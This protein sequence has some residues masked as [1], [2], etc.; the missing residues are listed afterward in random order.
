MKDKLNKKNNDI[1]IETDV[2]EN[3]NVSEQTAEEKEFFER[4][5]FA[6]DSLK[7]NEDVEDDEMSS[8]E[9][10]KAF[11]KVSEPKNVKK[12]SGMK[13]QIIILVSVFL[14]AAILLGVYEFILK[15]GD[16]TDDVLPNIYTLSSNCYTIINQVENDVQIV[17]KDSEDALS[18]D[19]Y[20]KY[21][22]Y[23]AVTF[24]YEFDCVSLVYGEGDA[25][26]TVRSG[27][28]AV[29]YSEDEFFNTLE[30]GKRFSFNGERLYGAAI[31]EVTGRTDLGNAD[32]FAR[33]ALPGY[34]LDG[35]TL[36]STNRPFMYPSI[37]RSDVSNVV[38]TN[39]YGSYK[40]YRMESN[41]SYSS[42]FYFEGAEFC[43]YNQELFA[44]F[45]VNCTYVLTYGKVSNVRNLADFGLASD[46]DAN[47]II[48]I[49]TID[50]KYHK[51]LIGDEIPATGGY[52]AKYYNKDFVYILDSSY[53]ND[54]LR[55]LTTLL[56]ANLGYIISSTND[57]YSVSEVYINY[58]NSDTDIYITQKQDLVLSPN[59]T[60][61]SSS[62]TVT[63]LLNDKTRLTGDYIDWTSAAK[64]FTGIKPSDGK[65]MVIQMQLTNYAYK[66]NQYSVK[67]GL[68]RDSSTSAALPLSVKV[69]VYIPPV[70]ETGDESSDESSGSSSSTGTYVEVASVSAFDQ[71]DKSYKQYSLSFNYEKQI[72]AIKIVVTAP[73]EGYVVFDEITA[74]A[75]GK[76]AI[77]NESVTGIWKILSPENYIQPGS[78]YAVPDPSSFANTL[79]GI[80][81]LVGDEVMEYNIYNKDK[82]EDESKQLLAEY[83]LDN[84]EKVIYYKYQNYKSYIYVSALQKGETDADKWYYAF[85]NVSYTDDEGK[86]YNI[87]PNIIVKINYDTAA[88]L[89][90]SP[91]DL[92]DRS[93]FTMYIDKIDTIE[94]AFGD[95]TYLFDL[96]DTDNNGKM[97]TVGYNGGYVDAQNFRYV[98]VSVLE[99]TRVGTYV[100]AE[101]EITED[102][103]IFRFTMHSELKD[104][105][106]KFYR[107]SSTK[108]LYQINGEYSEFYDKLVNSK[109][110]PK[111]S[112]PTPEK[113]ADVFKC[114]TEQGHEV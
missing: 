64:V 23:F 95:K 45:I 14:V 53:G 20:G 106:L 70:E 73:T 67:F 63:S 105:E 8:G 54:V 10:L 17:F 28:K 79:Y 52:Y 21:L 113:F 15:P 2:P 41:G 114:L 97:D 31:L 103:L 29:T 98:Y 86:V 12:F 47:A 96:Q 78:N 50:G 109:E 4:Q 58:K 74:Y 38:V 72:K 82:T 89:A 101:G 68:V 35:D 13:K 49:Y 57:T 42:E 80:T 91:S 85:A 48:E 61:Y 66:T 93:A 19:T 104:T 37:T 108:V 59:I 25:F 40:A 87:S 84:P 111:T 27:D 33:W 18:K 34:D 9:Y 39:Q 32:S 24:E 107:V 102:K 5:Y 110:F 11:D 56:T 94:M 55:P 62:Q 100:P 46:E 90:W 112:Q 51:I 60:C 83:G 44:S 30:N 16:D 26:C 81:T 69:F 36:S 99:C 75:D 92:I 3:E 71:G 77:P 88:Y 22:Y 43:Q 1:K 7:E 6:G 76:D 65:D